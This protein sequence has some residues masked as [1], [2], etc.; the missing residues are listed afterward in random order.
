[1][2]KKEMMMKK[3]KMVMMKKMKK[4][5]IKGYWRLLHKKRGEKEH[6]RDVGH[7]RGSENAAWGS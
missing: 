3:E 5:K 4:M 7:G 6:G 1:M 2:M